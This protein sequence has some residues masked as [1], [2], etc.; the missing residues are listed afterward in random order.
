VPIY[1]YKCLDCNNRSSILQLSRSPSTPPACTH[2]QST[3]LER[4][5]SRFASPKSDE[6]RMESLADDDALA[7]L[8]EQDP[9]SMERLMKRMGD[10]MG[11]DV[12]E[13]MAQAVDSADESG[14]DLAG[15]DGE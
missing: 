4:L 8:D 1:E 2:C 3:R 10:E 15:S 7:G 11:E 5:L 14:S 6:A 9:A 12:S 13:E